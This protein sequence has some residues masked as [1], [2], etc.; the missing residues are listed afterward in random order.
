[1]VSWGPRRAQAPGKGSGLPGSAYWIWLLGAP[2]GPRGR[3]KNEAGRQTAPREGIGTSRGRVL[4]KSGH[5]MSGSKKSAQTSESWCSLLVSFLFFPLL[6]A[7]RGDT[8]PSGPGSPPRGGDLEIFRRGLLEVFR[9]CRFF[10]GFFW[11]FRRSS[12]VSAGSQRLPE[13]PRGF[14]CLSVLSTFAD[15]GRLGKMGAPGFLA[16]LDLRGPLP[17]PRTVN[18]R[19][20][21]RNRS[22]SDPEEAPQRPNQQQN[23]TTT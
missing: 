1:M 3:R 18:K 8:S 17:G 4:K 23:T 12:K 9:F 5:R 7:V 2:G 11:C 10:V 19:F 6:A 13:G 20:G 21:T 22:P 16:T 14:G 15:I